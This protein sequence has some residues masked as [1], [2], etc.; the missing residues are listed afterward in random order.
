MALAI[1]CLIRIVEEHETRYKGKTV[2]QWTAEITSRDLAVSNAAYAVFCEAIVPDLMRTLLQD[3]NDS[4]LR[5]LLVDNLN[6]L[7]G[8]N[9]I[10]EPADTR[11]WNA[12]NGIGYSGAAG[13]Q[14]A[15][16]LL[17]L[18]RGNDAFLRG[19]AAN[20][21]GKLGALHQQ[22]IPVLIQWLDD[23]QL[24]ET[25]AESLAGY[26]ARARDAVPKLLQLM[27]VKD[28]DL[29]HAV[30]TALTSIDPA[31]LQPKQGP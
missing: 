18:L 4:R 19:A 1:L 10:F 11:R 26:G 23:E 14:V 2:F 24:R 28:K 9:I 8:V 30:V 22:V 16:K 31:Q 21:L 25:A 5:L 15:P 20:A 12:A 29:H 6:T 7:P 3:T 17:E 27:T 13:V